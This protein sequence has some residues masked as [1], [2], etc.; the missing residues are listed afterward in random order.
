MRVAGLV[1]GAILTPKR[2]RLSSQSST[3]TLVFIYLPLVSV[4]TAEVAAGLIW[5][6][7]RS[8][9]IS[10]SRATLR[11]RLYREDGVRVFNLSGSHRGFGSNLR[12]LGVVE[13]QS[14]DASPVDSE[15]A[16]IGHLSPCASSINHPTP[17]Q[18][19]QRTSSTSGWLKPQP[20]S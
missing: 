10:L 1:T 2:D 6:A 8:Q 14:N 13:A 11:R 4:A 9:R 3:R 15:G 16:W 12:R 17:A 5:L 7:I 19:S 18:A 20:G